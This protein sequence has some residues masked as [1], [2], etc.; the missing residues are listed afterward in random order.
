MVCLSDGLVNEHDFISSPG[1]GK[2]EEDA[3]PF[4]VVILPLGPSSVLAIV[5]VVSLKWCAEMDTLRVS[6]LVTSSAT[7]V[8]SA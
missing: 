3:G 2:I 8:Y 6:V 4:V 5:M 1:H 7:A